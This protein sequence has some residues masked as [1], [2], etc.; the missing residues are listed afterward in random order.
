MNGYVE[1]GYVVILGTLGTYSVS[2]VAR[3]R[4]ARRRAGGVLLRPTADRPATPARSAGTATVAAA[5]PA[6]PGSATQA[7]GDVGDSG[8]SSGP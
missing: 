4:A 3:E 6:D 1:A 7:R 8:T 2:L 5:A